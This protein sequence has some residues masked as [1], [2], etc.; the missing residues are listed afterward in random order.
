MNIYSA[1]QMGD[2][3]THHCED[4]LI[5]KKIG[6]D[7]ILCAVMDGCS[8]AMNSHFASTLTGKILR[9][10]AIEKGYQELYENA[11]TKNLEEQLKEIVQNLFNEMALVK[12]RLMLDEKELLSTVIILLYNFRE[13]NRGRSNLYQWRNNRI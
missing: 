7:K 11:C 4:D 2:Y 13:D 10:T 12:N 5:I 3:H 1:L 9:K 6:S 8:T